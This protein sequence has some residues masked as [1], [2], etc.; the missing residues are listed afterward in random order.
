MKWEYLITDVR[1]YVP[2]I[3]EMSDGYYS[4]LDDQEL[5]RLG[6]D[7]WEMVE[8]RKN[9]EQA[10][11]KRPLPEPISVLTHGDQPGTFQIAQPPRAPSPAADVATAP[12]RCDHWYDQ[13]GERCDN[14]VTHRCTC[15]RCA[16]DDSFHAC[17]SHAA[18][19]GVIGYRHR[20]TYPADEMVL[21]LEV[22]GR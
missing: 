21:E 15:R 16:R 1:R 20:R 4:G 9:G 7:G 12:P 17:A 13:T 11:F 3:T 6:S 19:P 2:E 18:M 8:A 14:P 5:N 10:V 22:F